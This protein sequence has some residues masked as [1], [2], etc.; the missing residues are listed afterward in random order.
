MYCT[1]AP[2]ETGG[3]NIKDAFYEDLTHIYDKLPENVIK[4]VLSDLNVSVE[5]KYI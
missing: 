4:L 3:E 5:E 2:T 1:L